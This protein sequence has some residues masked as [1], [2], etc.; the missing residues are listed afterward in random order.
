LTA[1][2]WA[3]HAQYPFIVRIYNKGNRMNTLCNHWIFVPCSLGL[4]GE[5]G[6]SWLFWSIVGNF[7]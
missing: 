1:I 2:F 6:T 5:G 3:N 4:D 7:N